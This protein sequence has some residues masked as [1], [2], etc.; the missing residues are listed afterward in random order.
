MTA[1]T[2]RSDAMLPTPFDSDIDRRAAA[3]RRLRAEG[4]VVPM[5]GLEGALAAVSYEAVYNGLAT[6][7]DFGGSAGQDDVPD[8]DKNIAA[9]VE[10]RHGKVRRIMNSV[11]AF[12]KSQQIEPYLQ[13]LVH[14]LMDE[15]MAEAAINGDEGV[16]VVRRLATPIP[17][18]AM[19][20]LF[21][22]PESDAK[23]YE[24]WSRLGGERY[25]KALA[26]GES[27]KM[28]ELNPE[29][30]SY[31]DE[32]LQERLAL[33]RDAWPEDAITRFL[34]TEVDG[35]TL[36]PRNIRAQIMFMIGA[37]SDTTKN[38]IGNL[39]YRLGLDQEAYAA[40]R[41]DP[42]LVD[43][44]IEESLRMDA[45]AQFMVR[46]CRQDTELV[47]EPVEAGTKVLMCIGSGNHDASKFEDPDAFRLDRATREHLSFGSGPHICPGATLA[48]LEV[49]TL[50]REFT[51]RIASFRI[52]DEHYDSLP[53]GMLQGQKSLRI[54]VEPA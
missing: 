25:E 6:V 43:V 16:D 10:P 47:G 42:E 52:V 2:T 41:E 7:D 22:F 9:M 3:Y 15:M 54:V 1:D 48:R 45:P 23:E 29:Q 40:L 27:I 49:R 38:V 24:K 32:K 26:K 8:I 53:L 51:K 35:E 17:P 19:S 44:A 36:D 28:A 39:I 37:G 46:N 34:T 18:A 33:P 31:I 11:V 12:H 13:D 21:G 4:P 50:M 30:R 5:P 20:R 14:R